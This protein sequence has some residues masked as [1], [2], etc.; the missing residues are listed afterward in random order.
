MFSPLKTCLFVVYFNQRC[1]RM[2]EIDWKNWKMIK[3]NY[4]MH[5]G[6]A[7]RKNNKKQQNSK[8]ATSPWVSNGFWESLPIADQQTLFL[9]IKPSTS[10][11]VQT[12]PPPPQY[13]SPVYPQRSLGTNPWY[14]NHDSPDAILSVTY[15]DQRME[16]AAP[17]H[18]SKYTTTSRKRS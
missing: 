11:L 1:V 14:S 17:I 7:C 13:M 3:K 12:T 2:V 6:S 18:W 10:I 15:M 9:G 4:I 5:T 16:R 8:W